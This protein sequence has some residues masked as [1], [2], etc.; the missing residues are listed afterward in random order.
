MRRLVPLGVVALAALAG[1]DSPAAAQTLRDFSVER[2]RRSETSLRAI[3]DFAAG[4]LFIR[5]STS[6]AL[7][8][9]QLAY[10]ADRYEPVGQ[11]DATRGTVHLGV[12]KRPERKGVPRDQLPQR[13]VVELS[14]D[15]DLTIEANLGAA[16]SSLELGGLRIEDLAVSTGASRTEVRFS[17]ANPG[18][19]RQAQVTTG[20]AEFRVKQLGNSGCRRW[21]IEG[22]VGQVRLDLDGAWP[23]GAEVRVRMTVGAVVL[24]AP[25]D[26]GIRIELDRFLAAFERAGFRRDGNTYVSDNYRSARRTVDLTI[27]TTLG[28]VKVEWR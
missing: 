20:A 12:D 28:N 10:D 4:E 23:E 8:R 19:C 2:G 16:E 26:L 15:V 14:P 21:T 25:R 13:A 24:E 7:Y 1:A 27:E 5:P 18:R 11:Y 3:V 17:R 22:G 9:L 6:N